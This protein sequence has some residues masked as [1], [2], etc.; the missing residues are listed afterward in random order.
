MQA[1]KIEII[2]DVV[3]PWCYIGRQHLGLASP[4]MHALQTTPER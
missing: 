2:S 4:A 1:L 3:C